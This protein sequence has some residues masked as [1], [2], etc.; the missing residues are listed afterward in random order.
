MNQLKY[1]VLGL[2]SGTS[3]DG[4]DI[5]HAHIWMSDEK[6]HFSIFEAVTI[7]YDED[8]KNALQ[9][10]HLLPEKELNELSKSYG[11][12]LGETINS[13]ILEHKI[14]SIDFIS[15]HGHTVLHNPTQKIT[16]QIGNGPEIWQHTKITTVC[17]FRLQDVL[18]GGQGAPLVPIGDQLLFADFAAC[19]NLGGFAN[20]SLTA[21]AN[22][23]AFD[24]CPVNI[25]LNA[26]SQQLGFA[27]DEDG[28]IARS[29]KLIPELL[30]DLN[31]LDFYT[32][33]PPKSLGREWVEEHVLPLLHQH[34]NLP[35]AMHTFTEHAAQQIANTLKTTD[36]HILV[37]GGGSFNTYL[38]NRINTLSN[39]KIEVPDATLVNFKEALIFAFLGVL[40]FSN[41]PNCLKSVTG[42]RINHSSGRIYSV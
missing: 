37:T 18:L 31:K 17:D 4:L 26:L 9:N 27:Y 24:I 23:I 39:K 22:R 41:R 20:I 7:A 10:A 21:N 34:Q 40:R 13:F 1:N 29:G 25:V 8:W 15:S 16:L 36:G 28:K 14:A 35:N 2:M 5:C 6:W 32:Q 12:F 38:I 11:T 42:A 3:L 19:L 30:E 33:N